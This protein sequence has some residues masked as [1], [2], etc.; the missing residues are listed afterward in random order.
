ME[1][2]PC[3]QCGSKTFCL[4]EIEEQVTNGNKGWVGVCKE[5]GYRSTSIIIENYEGT[6]QGLQPSSPG[7]RGPGVLKIR[8]YD[9][10]EKIL[11]VLWEDAQACVQFLQLKVGDRVKVTIDEKLWHVEKLH[12]IEE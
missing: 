11:E 12:G 1:I 7:L 9:G 5:C 10:T 3:P 6:F 2:L 4:T 8:L